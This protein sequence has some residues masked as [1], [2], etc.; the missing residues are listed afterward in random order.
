MSKVLLL[1]AVLTAAGPTDDVHD[2]DAAAYQGT[3]A[4]MR[5][6]DFDDDS[7][8]GEVLSADGMNVLSRRGVRHASMIDLRSHFI[9]ELHRITLDL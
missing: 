7:V 1:T 6:Y 2:A 9:V 4:G 5:Y 3:S 8:E